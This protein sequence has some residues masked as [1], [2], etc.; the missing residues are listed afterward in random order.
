M[1]VGLTACS[2]LPGDSREAFIDD[3]LTAGAGLCNRDLVE[4]LVDGAPEAITILESCGHT[5]IRDHEGCISEKVLTRAGGHS[6]ARTLLSSGAGVGLSQSLRA[7]V[8]KYDI[9][10]YEDTLVLQ[11]IKDGEAVCGI[12]ALDLAKGE[13]ISLTA[14][15][16]VLCTGG[17]GWLFYPQTSNNRTAT[18]DGYALAFRAGAEL[19]DMEQIQA[20]P[21]SITH[22]NAYRG[23]IC[24]EPVV[25][26]PAGRLING[27]G[28]VF[29]D[30]NINR[31]DRAAVVRSMASEITRGN[32]AEHGGLLLDLQPNLGDAEGNNFRERIRATG[33]FDSVLPAY[34]KKAYAWEEP[35]EV[36]PTAHYFMG[37]VRV[38]KD[39]RTTVPGLFAA[40]EVQSGVHGANRLGSAALTEVLV[41]GIRAGRAAAGHAKQNKDIRAVQPETENLFGRKGSHRPITLMRKLQAK[42]WENV[43]LVRDKETLAITLDFI[44]KISVLALD[45]STSSQPV[46]NTEVADA[47]ELGFMLDTA[48]CVVTSAL[49]REESRGAHLRSDF[50]VESDDWR[51]NIIIWRKEDGSIGH[52]LEAAP[53]E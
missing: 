3:M 7:A 21:F 52:R 4:A 44:H 1:A 19:A 53:H 25:A 20:L 41:F 15:A 32:V 9:S 16:V 22:P 38:D 24:G 37:G 49:L 11:L 31:M 33:I 36:L 17:G 6:N 8:E 50:P 46:Y 13:Q 2:G 48:S 40:G 10:L 14:G 39:G 43:G 45:V 34:G 35:W 5:F 27:K 47:I 51:K 30:G 12:Q 18:G 28:K 29:L 26:G 42:L 23:L